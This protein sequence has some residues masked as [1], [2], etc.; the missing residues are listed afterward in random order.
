MPNQDAEQPGARRVAMAKRC[1]L[2]TGSFDL[3]TTA[4]PCDRA[5]ECYFTVEERAELLQLPEVQAAKARN[6]AYFNSVP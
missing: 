3:D 5:T 6:L 4:C 1:C 2:L